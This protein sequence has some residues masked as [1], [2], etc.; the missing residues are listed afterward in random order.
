MPWIMSILT[1]ISH[2]LAGVYLAKPRFG[3]A[4]TAAVWGGYGLL[5]LLFPLV[6]QRPMGF[7]VTF[8]LQLVLLL[9]T[10]QGHWEEKCFYLFSY[11]CAFTSLIAY[12]DIARQF[13]LPDHLGLHTLFGAV[14]FFSHGK[15]VC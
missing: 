11:A 15:H 13:W 4:V 3:R 7:S 2:V 14:A 1:A 6:L 5:F 10:A 9:L 12:Y 8:L